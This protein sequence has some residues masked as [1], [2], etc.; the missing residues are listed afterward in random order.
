MAKAKTILTMY[1]LLPL[2]PYV[3]GT[4]KIISRTT[5]LQVKR[6]YQ[7][8]QHVQRRDSNAC[9]KYQVE[10]KRTYRVQVGY[11]GIKP[12]GTSVGKSAPSKARIT[13]CD[14]EYHTPLGR[15]SELDCSTTKRLPIANDT[16]SESSRRDVSN[17]DL[18]GTDTTQTVEISGMEN[19]L[20][21]A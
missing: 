3:R 14:G 6:I 7:Y 18:F 21:G 20:R 19:R 2:R 5:V 9:S 13:V 8:L 16:A 4:H 15:F 10:R 17:P 11:E 1:N 12:S